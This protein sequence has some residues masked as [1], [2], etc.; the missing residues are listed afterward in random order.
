ME[1]KQ[2]SYDELKGE[3]DV[4]SAG[5]LV[6]CLGDFIAHVGRHIDGFD[7]VYGGLSVGQRN[8]EGKSGAGIM[9]VKYMA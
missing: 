1:E 6:M 2:S 5:D 3:W 7:G 4:H 9:C 8:L